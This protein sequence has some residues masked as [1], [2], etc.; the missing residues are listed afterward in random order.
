M[1]VF[2]RDHR[3]LV[4]RT[5]AKRPTQ[6]GHRWRSPQ[7]GGQPA[8]RLYRGRAAV[9]ED[10]FLFTVGCFIVRIPWCALRTPPPHRRR[11]EQRLP[12]YGCCFALFPRCL[13]LLA[14]NYLKIKETEKEEKGRRNGRG[15][16]IPIWCPG[17]RE[18]RVPLPSPARRKN[19]RKLLSVF[20]SGFFFFF[21]APGVGVSYR[22][23]WCPTT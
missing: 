23:S 11:E 13:P 8:L 16:E 22:S 3:R 17:P 15:K 19:L 20:T 6:I 7:S 1:V 9:E 18:L 4:A 5:R 21:S 2:E 14:I 10:H 12:G